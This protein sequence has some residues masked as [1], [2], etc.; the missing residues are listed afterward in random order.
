MARLGW[1]RN[2]TCND[3]T[4]INSE[5][6]NFREEL[7]YHLWKEKDKANFVQW[8]YSSNSVDFEECVGEESYLEIISE[9]YSGLSIKQLKQLIFSRFSSALRDEFRKYIQTN[10]KVLKATC[11]KTVGPDYDGK[12]ERDWELEVGKEYYV[13]GIS[14]NLKESTNQIKFQVFDPSYSETTP[15]FIPAELFELKD[16]IIPPNYS[17]TVADNSLRLNPA[18]FVDKSYVAVEYSFWEDYFD[19]HEKAVRIFKSTMERLGVELDE[20][21]FGE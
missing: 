10:Q 18:E 2:V 11:I 8:I 13:L 14:I 16:K 6:M 9:N 15:Y 20:E 7:F 12:S 1:L 17:I 5:M 3:W 19:N 21:E 4:S